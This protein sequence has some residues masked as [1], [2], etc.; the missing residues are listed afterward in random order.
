MFSVACNYIP[1]DEENKQTN[2]KNTVKV[3]DSTLF[4]L[5][6][7]IFFKPDV[8]KNVFDPSFWVYFH[9]KGSGEHYLFLTQIF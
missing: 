9:P 1:I 8:K 4:P 6:F 5:L 7:S 3:K 2:I